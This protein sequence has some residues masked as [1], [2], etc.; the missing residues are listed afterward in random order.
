MRAALIR[1]VGAAGA[2]RR[3]PRAGGRSRG[4]RHR[5]ADQP[6]RPLDRRGPLLRRPAEHPLRARRRGRRAHGR[7]RAALV[8]DRRRLPRRRVDG[9]ARGRCTSD[10]A[11]ELPDG[12]RRPLAGC[13][14]VAGHR[15]VGAARHRAASE[16]GETVLILGATAA[17]S[18]RSA[19]R[20]RSCWAPGRVIA[21]GRDAER[22]SAVE[23]DAH[24]RAARHSGRAARGGGGWQSTSCSTRSGA[25]TRTAH[26]GDE[27]ERPARDARR[28]GGRTAGHPRRQASCAARR[29]GSSATATGSRRPR[30]STCAFQRDVRPR[31]GRGSDGVSTRSC[32]STASPQP[33]SARRRPRT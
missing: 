13:L 14:G 17:W 7:G 24:V 10:R 31:R 3:S 33:G 5:R 15:R 28:P 23:A 1:E 11:V 16:E 29:S 12:V 19:C 20:R 30:S 22:R 21:A 2:R 26:R 6:G 4:R 27:R 32:R 8:R 18:A 25:S 9:R